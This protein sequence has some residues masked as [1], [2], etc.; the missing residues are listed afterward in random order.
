MQAGQRPERPA[1][2]G[3]ERATTREL[4]L[5]REPLPSDEQDTEVLGTLGQTDGP[6]PRN[7][8]WIGADERY[9]SP[10]ATAE[11]QRRLR[12]IVVARAGV[13][14]AQE[15]E[16]LRASREANRLT[17]QALGK[18]NGQRAH[19]SAVRL[20][21]S[22]VLLIALTWSLA[23]LGLQSAGI[24]VAN[25]T[26]AAV[27]RDAIELVN[28]VETAIGIRHPRPTQTAAAAKIRPPRNYRLP[29]GRS[30]RALRRIRP[31]ETARWWRSATG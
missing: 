23:L 14:L 17:E 25:L 26:P 22:V 4:W 31:S 9:E 6:R 19:A 15:E 30:G 21:R 2:D 1:S 24:P 12:E 27:I 7:F 3:T 5:V 11:F 20:L 28:G 29:S 10:V 8:D 18:E 16:N 13:R